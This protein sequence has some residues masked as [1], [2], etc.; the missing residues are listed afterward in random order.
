[1][2]LVRP[3]PLRLLVAFAAILWAWSST[4][5]LVHPFLVRHATCEHGDVVEVHADGEADHASAAP[6]PDDQI[7]AATMDDDHDHGCSV[8]SGA[9]SHRKAHPQLPSPWAIAQLHPATWWAGAPARG[10]P[11]AFA[12]KTSPPALA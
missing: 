12:P 4:S 10:P 11:L 9:S 6:S 1:M 8:P 5:A 3:L 7:G 2:W